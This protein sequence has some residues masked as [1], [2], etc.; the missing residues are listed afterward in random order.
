MALVC[1]ANNLN[2]YPIVNAANQG[3]NRNNIPIPSPGVGGACLSK[4]PYILAS[5][6][7]KSGIDPNFL[8][9]KYRC[10]FRT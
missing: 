1:H 4:D 7:R 2:M 8:N 5:V 9:Y 10:F 6:C 3:Y